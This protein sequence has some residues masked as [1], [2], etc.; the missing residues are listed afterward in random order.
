MAGGIEMMAVGGRRA[1]QG[2]MAGRTFVEFK[3]SKLEALG[4]GVADDD[5]VVVAAEES[6]LVVPNSLLDGEHG[7]VKPSLSRVRGSEGKR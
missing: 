2:L 6:W 5:G 7:N 3:A 1:S 4:G